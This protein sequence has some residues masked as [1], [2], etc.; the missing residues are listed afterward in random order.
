VATDSVASF[1]GELLPIKF[2]L[3]LLWPM[4]LSQLA[5]LGVPSCCRG[6]AV[7]NVSVPA[8]AVDVPG[9][10]SACA[11]VPATLLTSLL[12]L[13]FPTFLALML[14]LVSLL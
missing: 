8:T 5:F 1:P 4:F 11:A 14:L 6:L 3:P 2:L 12:K 10:T 13:V 7:V 9:G